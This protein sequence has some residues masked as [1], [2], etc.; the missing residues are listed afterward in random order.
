MNIFNIDINVQVIAVSLQKMQFLINNILTKMQNLH[1]DN[2][3]QLTETLKSLNFETIL[4][5]QILRVEQCLFIYGDE[6]KVF[7]NVSSKLDYLP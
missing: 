5:C 6:K 1:C 3:D 7:W 2:E 4:K